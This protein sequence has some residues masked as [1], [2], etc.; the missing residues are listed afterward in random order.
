MYLSNQN[1]ITSKTKEMSHNPIIPILFRESM[2]ENEQQNLAIMLMVVV[3]VFVIC[4]IL[5]MVCNLLDVFYIKADLL[6]MV[7]AGFTAQ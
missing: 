2:E 6:V 7:I 5:A 1:K 4:N 3:S